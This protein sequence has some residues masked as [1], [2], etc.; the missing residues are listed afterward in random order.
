MPLKLRT[1]FQ[2]RSFAFSFAFANICASVYTGT[3]LRFNATITF[4]KSGVTFKADELPNLPLSTL[5]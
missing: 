4:R 2:P 5:A 1:G 3:R